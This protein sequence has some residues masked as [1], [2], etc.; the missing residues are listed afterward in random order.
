MAYG[1]PYGMASRSI[2]ELCIL[3]A[4]F[5]H[6]SLG[7]IQIY[8]CEKVSVPSRNSLE[9]T[10]GGTTDRVTTLQKLQVFLIY[11]KKIIS[12][13]GIIQNIRFRFRLGFLSFIFESRSEVCSTLAFT[14]TSSFIND[15]LFRINSEFVGT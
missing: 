7:K 5:L 15:T 1:L 12:K 9:E 8:R 4:A 2:A 10:G 14:F 6:V 13:S 11:M 3:V